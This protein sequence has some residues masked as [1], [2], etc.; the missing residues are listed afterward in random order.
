M[1]RDSGVIARGRH[2]HVYMYWHAYSQMTVS[3]RIPK[4]ECEVVCL[5]AGGRIRYKWCCWILRTAS[6]CPH[7]NLRA[8]I[9][10]RWGSCAEQLGEL[11]RSKCCFKDNKSAPSIDHLSDCHQLGLVGALPYGTSALEKNNLR[12]FLVPIV[13][14]NFLRCQPKYGAIMLTILFNE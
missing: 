1:Y 10:R 5:G 9:D 13:D 3:L 11:S 8:R 14:C 4:A 7:R 12:L 2:M 6:S